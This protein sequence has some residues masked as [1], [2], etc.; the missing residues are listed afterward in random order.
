MVSPVRCELR[1]RTANKVLLYET[2]DDRAAFYDKHRTT[3]H[4]AEFGKKIGPWVEAKQLGVWE[5]Q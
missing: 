3:P 5:I 1:S 2:Y 4:F